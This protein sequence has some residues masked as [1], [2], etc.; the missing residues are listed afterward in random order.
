MEGLAYHEQADR[1]SWLRAL[2]FF[3]EIFEDF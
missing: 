1:R 2:A 3:E